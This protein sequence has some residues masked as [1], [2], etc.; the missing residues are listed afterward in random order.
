MFDDIIAKRLETPRGAII[1]FGRFIIVRNGSIVPEIPILPFVVAKN[2]N[3][4]GC[5]CSCISMQIDGYGKNYDEAKQ[6]MFD[7]VLYY[8]KVN[9]EEYGRSCWENLLS[10]FE[11]TE[12]TAVYWN[13]Y[14][15]MQLKMAA[16]GLSS[17]PF[18][19]YVNWR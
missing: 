2:N 7:N 3:D 16:N 9:F 17:D 10:L 18:I 13:A 15:A 8:L 11:V 19:E 1:G 5:I 6:D 12:D 4:D 14:F